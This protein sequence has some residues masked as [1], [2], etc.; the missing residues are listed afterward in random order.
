MYTCTYIYIYI[1]IYIYTI[2]TYINIPKGHWPFYTRY[3]L[4][5]FLCTG[6]KTSLIVSTST[7]VQYDIP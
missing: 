6:S 5:L 3:V 1:Y 2:Y 7:L 4:V